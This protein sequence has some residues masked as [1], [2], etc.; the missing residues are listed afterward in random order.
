MCQKLIKRRDNI[1]LV[2]NRI[3]HAAH[4]IAVSPKYRLAAFADGN[5]NDEVKVADGVIAALR[6]REG[7]DIAADRSH[8]GHG[9]PVRTDKIALSACAAQGYFFSA[10]IER[11][12][13]NMRVLVA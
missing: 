5:L 1:F 4:D 9:V 3:R 8:D 6:K 7:H 13:E 2:N 12:L 10:S 11:K